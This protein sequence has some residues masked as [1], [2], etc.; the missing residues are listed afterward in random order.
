MHV[1]NQCIVCV[2]SHLITFVILHADILIDIFSTPILPVF[3]H[4]S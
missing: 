3:T 4:V 1:R 2:E